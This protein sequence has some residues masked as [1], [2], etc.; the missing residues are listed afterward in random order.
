MLP[1]SEGAGLVRACLKEGTLQQAVQAYDAIKNSGKPGV[2][3][4]CAPPLV[5][6]QFSTS[7]LRCHL[8]A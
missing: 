5:F 2:E 6:R 1:V 8:F 7:G 3:L 4:T